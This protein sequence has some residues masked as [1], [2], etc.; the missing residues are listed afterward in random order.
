MRPRDLNANWI[1]NRICLSVPARGVE[2]SKLI[3][4]YFAG[5]AIPSIL[6]ADHAPDRLKSLISEIHAVVPVVSVALGNSGDATQ[7]DKALLAVDG[8]QVHLNQPAT[9]SGYAV[10]YT[11]SKGWN[12]WV[13]GV[14]EPAGTPGLVRI[15]WIHTSPD[16]GII[17]VDTVA[18]WFTETGTTALKIHP[19]GKASYEELVSIAKAAAD[20]G[21]EAVEPA[22]GITAENF[23]FVVGALFDGGAKYV[24]PHIFSAV[25]DKETHE[26]SVDKIETFVEM[27]TVYETP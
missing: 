21:I 5:C 11:A 18:A 26:V 25:E 3:W 23:H 22:G 1:G 8:N 13:N 24:L 17:P 6:A 27:C 14:V 4:D 7:W 9:Q 10:G 16:H 12:V 15:P 2:D 19:V 20:N